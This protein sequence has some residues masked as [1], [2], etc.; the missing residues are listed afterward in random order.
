MFWSK[1]QQNRLG[2]VPVQ[3]S[4]SQ[5]LDF[6]VVI[7]HFWQLQC[8]LLAWL[9]SCFVRCT[10]TFLRPLSSLPGFA[11]IRRWSRDCL[12][13]YH[14]P[15][16]TQWRGRDPPKPG[17][18]DIPRRLRRQFG[19]LVIWPQ[20]E[21]LKCLKVIKQVRNL[22]WWKPNVSVSHQVKGPSRAKLNFSLVSWK[23]VLLHTRS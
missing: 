17:M 20:L 16:A 4:F 2:S 14:Q 1:L 7:T 12:L 8:L 23:I 21:V 3:G 6:F 19:L 5:A 22:F 15:F 11:T 10:H 13:T 9:L 18:Q